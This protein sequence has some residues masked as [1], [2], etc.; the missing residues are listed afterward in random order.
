MSYKPQDPLIEDDGNDYSGKY[1]VVDGY[2]TKAIASDDNP[3]E[4]V[5]KAK[6]L[7]CENPVLIYVEKE[8]I[9]C[10]YGAQEKHE[11]WPLDRG[12]ESTR[13]MLP[14][15][16]SKSPSVPHGGHFGKVPL[17]RLLRKV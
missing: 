15:R 11:P 13:N 8:G 14:S 4:A 3:A 9:V 2:D 17:S 10:I 1:V 6:K 7:D 12:R 16:G 5:R